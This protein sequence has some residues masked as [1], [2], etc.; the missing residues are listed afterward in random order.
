MPLRSPLP[1]S[2]NS[3][4]RAFLTDRAAEASRRRSR[5][6]RDSQGMD[7]DTSTTSSRQGYETHYLGKYYRNY[8]TPFP[9]ISYASYTTQKSPTSLPCFLPSGLGVFL[10]HQLPNHDQSL[11]PSRFTGFL[12]RLR[13]FGTMSGCGRAKAPPGAR[14]LHA[15]AK[16]AK[17]NEGGLARRSSS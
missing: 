17:T 2:F 10:P 11:H 9:D 8:N 4:A 1:V 14:S 6:T 16:S 13:W 15:D 7:P 5:P 3:P 12:P